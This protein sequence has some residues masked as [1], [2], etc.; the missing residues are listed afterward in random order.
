MKMSDQSKTENRKQRA[1]RTFA[2]EKGSIGEKS[3][4]VG[5]VEEENVNE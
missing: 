5:S 4:K 3:A 1:R 2:T